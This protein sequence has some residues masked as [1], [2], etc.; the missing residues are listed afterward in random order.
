MNRSER[1]PLVIPAELNDSHDLRLSAWGP[2]TK[3]YMGI[4]HIPDVRTGL[5]FD[6]SVFPGLYRRG[7][8]PPNVLWESGY[9]PWEAAPDLAYFRHRFEV[10]WKDQV[11]ADVDFCRLDETAVLVR[12]ACVNRTATAQNLVWHWMASL[13]FPP[14]RTYS[15][16]PLQMSRVIVPEG[17][18]WTE[19]LDYADLTLGFEPHRA[20]LVY[21][22]LRRGEMRAHGFTGGLGLGEGFGLTPGDR[23]T[24]RVA[25]PAP[26]AD[27]VL[28]LRYR[29]ASGDRL[30]LALAGDVTGAVTLLGSGDLTTCALS[31]GAPP[32]GS[33][34]LTLTPQDR[35]ALE[36]DGCAIV[37]QTAVAQLRFE[38]VIWNP[39]PERLPA[40][41]DNTLLLR[42]VHLP[43]V[44]GLAWDGAVS[45][46][47][48][49]FYCDDLDSTLRYKV[50]EHVQT[51]LRGPGEGHYTDVFI[52]PVFLEAGAER[53]SYG[54]ICIGSVEQVGARLAD[55]DPASPGWDSVHTQA[56]AH[57]VDLAPNP[58]GEIYRFSQE[59]MAATLLTNIVYPVRTRSTW[60]R[61][62]TPG[63]WWDCLY[64]WDSG[65]I[66]LGLAELD[67]DRAVDSLN[68]YTTA[69]GTSDAAFIHHGSPVP[70]Q[71][72]VFQELWNRTQSR[73]LLTYFYPR[74]Q[75]YHRFMAGRWGSSTTRTLKSNLIRTW[76]Y[77]YSSGG[78]D[79]YPPQ[80]Y[81]HQQNL[82]PV[83]TPVIST[84][85]VIRTAKIMRMAALALG[86]D[87]AEYD[88]D[89][90]QLAAALQTYAWDEDAGYFSYVLHDADGYPLDILRHDSGVN[91]NMGMDGAS[92]LAAGICTPEQ[93]T[94]LVGALMSPERMWCRYG[95]TTVDQTA[96]YYRDDGYWNGAVW[97]AHQWFFWKALLD[98]GRAD[99]AY[100]IAQTALDVWQTEVA[101]SY[102]CFEHFIARSGRGAGWHHFG[103]LSSPVLCWYG[104]Y[105]R[106]GRLTVGLDTWI[107]ALA[108]AANRRA[109]TATLRLYGPPHHMPV[110]IATLD[111]EADYSVT[112]NGASL[113]HHTRHPGTLEI[114]LPAG[115]RAGT[116]S[117]SQRSERI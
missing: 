115:A 19:A 8:Q 105:H 113:A 72:Y 68:A 23:V 52:R 15:S 24:Y 100:R 74:L 62:N 61:H 108:V 46:K 56:R 99:D 114:H 31:L 9:H 40:P 106:P 55:F 20:N 83:V 28:V 18:V 92:P 70:T 103:G 26:L 34:T 36:L 3:R 13:H 112:W 37:P 94:R 47:V 93:E 30:P 116:L 75:P 67:L 107:E 32:A 49:E 44:Y 39:V 88:A 110:V 65:F 51:T 79:D 11:Y 64:T 4:S 81:I 97:M 33:L 78:W 98:M 89:I 54:L 48:R 60:I 27:A 109:L 53:V 35:V 91:F 38:P 77:F 10:I 1:A 57:A 17:G 58:C 101:D 73:T 69:P 104:A 43:V 21:D 117:I 41:R 16:V 14:L 6:V 111:A 95:V 87:T 5:R 12:T 2:Y 22:G 25:L 80:V 45:F 84:A 29:M 90:A 66:G 50:H 59:R 102:N 96:P 71:F 85:Q 82:E 86:E 42:Y 63:R 7:I 76:D